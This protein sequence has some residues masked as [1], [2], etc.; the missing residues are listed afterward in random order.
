MLI[1]SLFDQLN[2]MFGTSLYLLFITFPYWAFFLFGYLAVEMWLRYI[3]A[4]WIFKQGSVLLELKLPKEMLKSPR[5]MEIFLTTALQQGGVGFLKEVYYDGRVKPWWSLELVSIEGQ[6]RFFIWSHKKWQPIIETQ[7]YAQYP[8]LEIYNVTD[9]D[10]AKKVF[11]DPV[12]RGMWGTYF[13]KSK[14]DVFPIKTYIDYELDKD[15]KEEFKIDPMTSMIEYLGSMK[16][17]EQAWFQILVQPHTEEKFKNGQFKYTETWD[18]KVLGAINTI[19]KT[20]VSEEEQKNKLAFNDTRLSPAERDKI[21]AMERN[22]SKIPYDVV[23]RAFYIAEEG[24]FNVINISGMIGAFRQYGSP[25]LN[26]ISL[27]WNTDVSDRT[28]DLLWLVSW[29]SFPAKFAENVVAK[30]KM[31]SAYKQ[32]SIFQYPYKHKHASPYVL[33]TEELATI[34]HFPGEVSQT[35][36]FERIASTKAGAPA[37]LPI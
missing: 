24:H 10:Y 18:K 7:L 1:P 6:V 33:T 22:L 36:T 31:L 15:P 20:T 11:Y 17:G 12:K 32:R 9:D 23:I 27:G 3:R 16:T 21:K 30:Y 4:N 29:L 34:F 14:S 8:Q 26:G 19:R 28:K 2:V 37:N 13:K 25:S 5:S 35:P